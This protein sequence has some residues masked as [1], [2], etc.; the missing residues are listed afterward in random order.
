MDSVMPDGPDST[1]RPVWQDLLHFAAN[2]AATA[3]GFDGNG[4]TLRLGLTEGDSAATA[5]VP[6]LGQIFGISPKIEGVRPEWLGYGVTPAFRPDQQCDRQPLPNMSADSGGAAADFRYSPIPAQSATDRRIGSDM[7]GP[8]S[9]VQ[10]LL[11]WLVGQL[12]VSGAPAR[13]TGGSLLQSLTSRL[14]R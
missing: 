10:S 8:P 5:L 4:T 3:A 14:G 2:L 12:H 11:R 13:V 7:A 6:G 1:G 9:A